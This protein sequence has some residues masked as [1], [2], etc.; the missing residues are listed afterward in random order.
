M[1]RFTALL[2][3]NTNSAV[4]LTSKDGGGGSDGGEM[5]AKPVS[6]KRKES[7]GADTSRTVSLQPRKKIML[8]QPEKVET[9]RKPVSLTQKESV[10]TNTKR[11]SVDTQNNSNNNILLLSRSDT[12]IGGDNVKKSVLFNSVSKSVILS[13]NSTVRKDNIKHQQA[14]TTPKLNISPK[15]A[16][17]PSP[18][19]HIVDVDHVTVKTWS[20]QKIFPVSQSTCL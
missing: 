12:D 7:V 4:I 10:I 18:S 16:V 8:K 17:T 20:R 3:T 11:S 15:P 19:Q 9:M 6:L 13:H 1:D 2:R 5:T 14:N